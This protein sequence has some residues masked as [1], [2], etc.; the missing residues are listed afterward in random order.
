VDDEPGGDFE[1]FPNFDL[2]GK[3]FQGGIAVRF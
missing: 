3:T 2:S 1:G